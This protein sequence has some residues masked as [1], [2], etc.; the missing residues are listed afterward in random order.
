MNAQIIYIS[1]EAYCIACLR[2]RLARIAAAR[3]AD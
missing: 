2:A 3:K 1:W